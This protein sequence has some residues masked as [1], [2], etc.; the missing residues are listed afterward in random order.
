MDIR[1]IHN[2]KCV[3]GN[4]L[5]LRN[6]IPGSFLLHKL[7]VDHP[8]VQEQPKKN[9]GWLLITMQKH[10]LDFFDKTL[11][12]FLYL[13]RL[14]RIAELYLKYPRLQKFTKYGSW[15]TLEY[16]IIKGPMTMLFTEMLGLWYVTSAF[17]AGLICTVIGFFLGE[18]WVWRKR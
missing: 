4:I 1:N 10:Q 7:M 2:T 15:I 9:I 14:D 3:N 11:V 17:I 13:V 6:R 5:S 18:F 8:R 12:S 16:W